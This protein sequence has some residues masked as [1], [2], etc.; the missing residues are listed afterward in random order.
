MRPTIGKDE[1]FEKI[2][3]HLT[4]TPVYVYDA[5]QKQ[6]VLCG[7]LDCPYAVHAATGERLS[8]NEM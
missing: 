1:A 2:R 4:L 8:L 5:E 6:Y 3:P 7:K